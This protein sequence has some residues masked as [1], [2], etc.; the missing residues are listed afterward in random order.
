MGTFN[1]NHSGEIVTVGNEES[2]LDRIE[3]K[4][5]RLLELLRGKELSISIVLD[6]IEVAKTIYPS[7]TR[8]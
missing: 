8:Q 3:K 7:V 4:M 2:Q 1:H 5:D 6:G